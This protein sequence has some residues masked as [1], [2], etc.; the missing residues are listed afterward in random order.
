MEQ[1]ILVLAYALPSLHI[2]FADISKVL[3]FL[4]TYKIMITPWICGALV[5]CLLEW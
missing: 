5:V 4:L 3:S 1:K 2:C